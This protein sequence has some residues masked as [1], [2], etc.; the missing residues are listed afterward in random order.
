[1]K[2]MVNWASISSWEIA[3]RQLSVSQSPSNPDAVDSEW[4]SPRRGETHQLYGQTMATLGGS[5]PCW[6]VCTA[7]P[8][9]EKGPPAQGWT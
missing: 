6:T 3:P 9:E 1:M 8:L 7:E 5:L 2:Q 4:L